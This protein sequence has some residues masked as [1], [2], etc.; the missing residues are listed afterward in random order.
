MVW[1][2]VARHRREIS[3]A[4]GYDTILANFI[5]PED[6]PRVD[7][8]LMSL[9]L[10]LHEQFHQLDSGSHPVWF[11]ESLANYYALKALKKSSLIMIQ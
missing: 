10:V 3:G 7:E 6:N 11:G 4:A 5:I 2:G 1:F 9:M 8:Q